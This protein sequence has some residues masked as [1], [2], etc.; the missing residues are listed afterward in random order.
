VRI[1]VEDNPNAWLET[2]PFGS[3]EAWQ[4]ICPTPCGTLVRVD[5]VEA[6]VVA[7]GMTP[8]APFRIQAGSGVALLSVDGGSQRARTWGRWGFALGLPVSLLGTAGFGYGSFDD[9][10]GLRAAGAITLGVGAAMLVVA[11]PLLAA[12][13]TKVKNEHGD[14]VA[15]DGLGVR[16]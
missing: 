7:P 15:S 1:A 16:F 10:S 3:S 8:S 9:R 11:L 12:G 2:R 4:R 14:L 13:T 5:G 6:R